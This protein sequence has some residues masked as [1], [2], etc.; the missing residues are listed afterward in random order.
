MRQAGIQGMGSGCA[1]GI[2]RAVWSKCVVDSPSTQL[3]AAFSGP[4]QTAVGAQLQKEA[5]R[6]RTAVLTDL[7]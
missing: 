3:G 4:E 7:W 1:L 6:A 5:C 2:W